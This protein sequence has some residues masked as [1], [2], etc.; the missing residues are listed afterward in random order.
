[1]LRKALASALILTAAAVTKDQSKEKI[2]AV[3]KDGR[4]KLANL[5][6]PKDTRPIV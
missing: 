4:R 6:E 3:I 1:M 5:I 2:I